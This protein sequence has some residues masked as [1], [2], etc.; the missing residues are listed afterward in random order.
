MWKSLQADPFPLG[1][2][3][4]LKWGQK[5]TIRNPRNPRVKEAPGRKRTCAYVGR[6][7]LPRP[8]HHCAVCRFGAVLRRMSDNETDYASSIANET[9]PAENADTDRSGPTTLSDLESRLAGIEEQVED[10]DRADDIE[11]RRPEWVFEQFGEHWKADDKAPSGLQSY[12]SAWKL[13]REW[14][15]DQGCVYLTDLTPRFAGRH[16]DWIVAHDTYEKKKISR[17]MHLS[18]I[19]TVVRHAQSRGWIDSSDVPD[20]EMWDE[21]KPDYENYDSV[22]KDPLRPERGGRITNW[23]RSNYF[24]G[25]P[26]VLWLLLFRYGFRV[27]AARALDRDSLVLSEPDNWPDE[28]SFRPHLRLE[29]R[30]ELGGE[31]DKGLTLKNKREELASRLV[32]LQPE[33]VDVFRHYVENGSPHGAIDSRKEYDEPDEYGLHGLLTGE[34]N[35]RLTGRTIGDR[36]HW[37]TCPT[38]YE[39]ECQYDGCREYRDEH[40]RNPYPSNRRKHCNETRSPHQVRHGAIT[41]LL[42]DHSH[43]TVARIVGTSPD[44]LRDVYDRAGEYRR[45]N[46]VAGDWLSD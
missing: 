13:F 44:T 35:A 23:V 1:V 5:T 34:H 6:Q 9:T 18:R 15:D 19:K 21:A 29:D 14:M 20:D 31:D 39:A 10:D 11:D 38:T 42:D 17:C 8:M 27:S 26:H 40:G 2:S 43:A 28:Q 30:P 45:M 46:R 3:Q 7:L 16:D 41:S 4:G 22:R 24:G 25:R 36:T 37:L 33:H 32:P 12:R